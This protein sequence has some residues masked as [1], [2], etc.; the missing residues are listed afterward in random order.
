[1]KQRRQWRALAARRDIGG[2]KIRDHVN[3][4][5]LRECGAIAQLPRAPF[6]GAM[7]DCVPVHADNIS[8]DP[9]IGLSEQFDGFGVQLRQFA[10]YRFNR[11]DPTQHAPKL[12]TK[13]IGVGDG[14]RRSW[15]DVGA[16][17]GFDHRDVDAIERG[18][19]HQPDRAP[20]CP[21]LR[22]RDRPSR[23]LFGWW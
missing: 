15:Y 3:A 22:R 12:F 21:Y 16:T 23:V 13:G 14:H 7:Q 6:G 10:F 19:A 4:K 5:P 20:Q 11:A 1:M 17:I 9:L 2:A 18:A 8:R